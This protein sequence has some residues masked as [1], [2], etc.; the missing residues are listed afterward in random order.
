MLRYVGNLH[1]DCPKSD[2]SQLLILNLR[3]GKAL[4]FLLGGFGNIRIVFGL[5]HPVN[6]ADDIS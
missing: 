2:N 6:P 5:L 3:P 1:A 4:L